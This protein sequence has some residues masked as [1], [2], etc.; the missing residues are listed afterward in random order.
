MIGGEKSRTTERGRRLVNSVDSTPN[1][2]FRDVIERL[3]TNLIK[4]GAK[5][6]FITIA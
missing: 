1:L 4:K 3:K 6:Y 2:F 5:K